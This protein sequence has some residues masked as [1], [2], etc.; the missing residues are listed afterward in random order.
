MKAVCFRGPPAV[1]KTTLAYAVGR[2]ILERNLIVEK[3]GYVSADMFAHISFDCG[4]TD[5]EIDFKYEL[6]RQSIK[7]LA[8]REYSIIFDD[9]YHRHQDYVAVREFLSVCGYEIS[10]FSVTAPLEVALGRNRLRFWKERIEDH[11]VELLHKLHNRE[12]DPS[13]VVIDT[14]FSVDYNCDLILGSLF[15]FNGG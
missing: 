6:I 8:D 4:Y 2:S 12:V 13:E 11:R 14:S 7:L 1:G 5:S 3:L 15:S 9:T 10:L